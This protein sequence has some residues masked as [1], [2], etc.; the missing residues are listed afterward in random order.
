MIDSNGD[1]FACFR[2]WHKSNAFP[3]DNP[4]RKLASKLTNERLN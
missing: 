1:S 3:K 2:K 4:M